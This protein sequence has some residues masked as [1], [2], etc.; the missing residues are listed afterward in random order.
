MHSWGWGRW[1]HFGDEPK[2]HPPCPNI[3]F[4][5]PISTLPQN[6][7]FLPI[8]LPPTYLPPTSPLLPPISYLRS[9]SPECQSARTG[10]RVGA[11]EPEW[12]LQSQSWSRSARTRVGVGALEPKWERQSQSWSRSARTRVGVGAPEPELEQEHQSQTWSGTH[13]QVSR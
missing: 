2:P 12:E 7:S 8:Y 5:S 13:F 3:F 11:P 4:F 6:I 10:A 9:P 1:S